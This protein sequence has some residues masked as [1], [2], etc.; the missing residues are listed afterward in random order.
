MWIPQKHS[1]S[2]FFRAPQRQN[3]SFPDASN[4]NESA[5]HV[6]DPCSIPELGRSPGEGNS[7]PPQYSFLENSMD[8][9]A[10][11]LQSMGSQSRTRLRNSHT[12]IHTHTH[13]HTHTG[14]T[15]IKTSLNSNTASLNFLLLN[16]Y[17]LFHLSRM[18][19]L[20]RQGLLREIYLWAPRVFIILQLVA[21]LSAW[22]AMSLV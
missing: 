12:H 7:N 8:R 9:G 21:S 16:Y 3:Q 15:K 4:G 18:R 14:K 6:G 20:E 13:T 11:Q 19:T 10:W 5:C 2:D 17:K 1:K 22:K